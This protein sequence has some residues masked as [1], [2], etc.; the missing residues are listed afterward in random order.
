MKASIA[1]L[2]DFAQRHAGQFNA[3]IDNQLPHIWRQASC[4][5]LWLFAR[6]GCKQAGHALLIESVSFALQAS[7]WLAC[8]LCPLNR[9][10]AEKYN[11]E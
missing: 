4:C 10:I 5:F 2:C 8:L 1:D 3:Q 6:P 7:A 9:W 11:R